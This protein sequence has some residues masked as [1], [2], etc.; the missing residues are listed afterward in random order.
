M[1]IIGLTGGIGSGKSAA[2]D[3]FRHLG[4]K[5]VDADQASR[6]VVEPGAPAL[7]D[8]AEH[9]G[10][11]MIL[12]DGHMDRA[13][14]RQRIFTNPDDKQ[15]LEQLLHPLINRWIRDE[16]AT[17][18]GPYAV[19]ESPLLLEIG[20]HSYVDRV[21]VVDVPEEVQLER[22]CAR[23]GNTRE[24]IEAI[25]HSQLPRQQRLDRADDVIDNSGSLQ[26]L[27]EEIRRLHSKYL[28]LAET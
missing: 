24:Q 13:A 21:A 16:L 14:M 9:F 20:Q 26:H 25:I 10:D 23:D 3:C 15:W 1:L 6:K 4:I 19:L 8:I 28:T 7:A 18:P 11:E 2:G 17:A 27:M 5:V 22:A 12:S